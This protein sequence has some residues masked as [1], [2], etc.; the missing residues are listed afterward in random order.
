MDFQIPQTDRHSVAL[1]YATQNWLDE[2]AT[3]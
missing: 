2:N 3:H 1:H